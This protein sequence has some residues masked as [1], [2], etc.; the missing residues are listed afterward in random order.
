[1]PDA[2]TYTVPECGDPLLAI[3]VLDL[4]GVATRRHRLFKEID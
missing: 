2:I 3:L 4:N 1:M